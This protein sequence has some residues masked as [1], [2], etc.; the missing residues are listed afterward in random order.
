MNNVIR[1]ALLKHW[2]I[3]ESDPDL[4]EVTNQKPLIAY[5]KNITVGGRINIKHRK[6]EQKQET[7]LSL[8]TPKGNKPCGNCSFCP[9]NINS[10]VLFIGGEEQVIPCLITCR[11]TYVVYALICPCGLYYIGKTKRCLFVRTK[12][13][14]FLRSYFSVIIIKGFLSLA[15]DCTGRS[16]ENLISSDYKAD[17]DITQDTYEEHSIIPDTPSALH[18]QD[19]SSH[20]VIP[21]LSTDPSQAGKQKKSHRRV[22]AHRKAYTEKKPFSCLEC[23]KCFTLKSRLFRHQ[24]TH[25]GEKP[26]SCSECGKCFIEKS[27]LVKHQRIHTGEKPFLCPECGKCFIGQSHLSRHQKIHTGVK[28]FPCPECEKGFIVK[29]HLVRH[30]RIHARE[31]PFS[32]PECGKCFSRKSYLLE[33]QNTHTGEKPFSCPECGKCFFHKSQLNIHKKTHTGEN[34]FSCPECEKC[35]TQKCNLVKHQQIH[36]V[37]K[38]RIFGDRER[39]GQ[40]SQGTGNIGAMI[41]PVQHFPGEV[42]HTGKKGRSQKKCSVCNRRG[43]QK[44]TTTQC[45]TCPDHPGLCIKNCFKE[46]HISME[47]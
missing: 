26:F 39:A 29:S 46:Y 15:D 3:L 23:G 35:F 42:P 14:K 21:V 24:K 36:T 28:P 40:S 6:L 11:T 7:W 8:A 37:L 2:Y 18:R 32:C 31:K 4:R 16:E 30:Q 1:K 20:P 13:A 38:A 9:L 33:H 10:R 34:P 25:T 19:L 41:V 47:Y 44:D 12:Y 43:I 17:D 5:R 22:V 27:D 45:D